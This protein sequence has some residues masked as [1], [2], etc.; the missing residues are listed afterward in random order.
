MKFIQVLP[1]T[2]WLPLKTDESDEVDFITTELEV[3]YLNIDQI[4]YISPIGET[5]RTMIKLLDNQEILSIE[6]LYKILNK[7]KN[8]K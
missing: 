2:Q 1:F 7:L 6:P 3:M 8:A 4:K 5:D